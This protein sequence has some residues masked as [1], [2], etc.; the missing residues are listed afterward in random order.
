MP[1]KKKTTTIT[2]SER[3]L[4][5]GHCTDKYQLGYYDHFYEEHFKPYLN[6]PINILEIGIRGGGS[7]KIWKEYFH[8]DSNVYGGDIENFNPIDG[9]TCYK[10]DMYTQEALDLFEDSYFDIVIDDGIHTYESFQK[11]MDL[12]YSKIKPKGVMIIEDIIDPSWVDPLL[13]LSE[14]IGYTK[15]EAFDMSGKQKYQDLLNRW[16]NGLYILKLTK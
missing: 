12:Y 14:S 1:R 7:I 5:G 6:S 11:V 3:Y 4:K 9:T 2:L 8:P 16:K 15:S 13:K 10:I